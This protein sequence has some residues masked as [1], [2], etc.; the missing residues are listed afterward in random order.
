[1]KTK[2]ELKGQWRRAR[3]E[4]IKEKAK[5]AVR[6]SRQRILATR[7]LMALGKRLRGKP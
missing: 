3:A 7:S 1:V 6:T 2:E 5:F 4:Q